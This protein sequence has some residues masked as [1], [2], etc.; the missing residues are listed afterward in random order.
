MSIMK[1][2]KNTPFTCIVG[3]NLSLVT[4]INTSKLNGNEYWKRNPSKLIYFL[5]TNPIRIVRVLRTQTWL[6]PNSYRNYF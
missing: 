4:L 5:N 6:T 2:Y 1:Y 3:C